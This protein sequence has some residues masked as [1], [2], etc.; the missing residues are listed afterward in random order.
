ML[1][2]NTTLAGPYVTLLT[3]QVRTSGSLFPAHIRVFPSSSWCTG[4]LR[5]SFFRNEHA[6]RLPHVFELRVPHVSYI[7]HAANVFRECPLALS[8]WMHETHGTSSGSIG[9]VEEGFGSLLLASVSN[10][11]EVLKQFVGFSKKTKVGSRDS[12]NIIP[13]LSRETLWVPEYFWKKHTAN[14]IRGRNSFFLML[15]F[16]RELLSWIGSNVSTRKFGELFRD[17]YRD[18][19]R[20]PPLV[21][22]GFTITLLH[23]DQ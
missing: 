15:Y 21:S 11:F 4:F 14:R 16:Y 8:T 1:N 7:C 9:T 20:C 6:E 2:W 10:K 17:S 3:Q 12:T 22:R 5:A 13:N 23:S 18:K 19:S